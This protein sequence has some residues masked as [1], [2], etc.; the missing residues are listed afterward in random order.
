MSILAAFI[1]P[2]PPLIVPQIGKGEEETIRE[3]SESFQK[4]AEKIALLKPDTIVLA[5]PHSVM[6]SDYLHISPGSTA[7]GDFG[8]FG[9]RDVRITVAY[10]T[11][12]RRSL[13]DLINQNDIPAG[14]MGERNSTLDHGTMVP[15]Y[16]INQQYRD[17]KLIRMSIS[18]LPFLTHYNIGKCISQASEITKKKVVF[19]ASGDLSHKLKTDGPYGFAKEGPIFDKEVTEA[20]ASANFLRFMTFDESF[21]ESAAECGLRSFIIM[22]GALDGKAVKPEL[23]SYQGPFGVGYAVASFEVVGSDPDRHFD[24]AYEQLQNSKIDSI[25]KQESE[26]VRLARM[27]LEHYL[28]T[29]SYMPIPGDTSAELTNRKAGTFVSLHKDGQLRGCIGTISPNT[30]SIAEEIIHNAV[31]AG[32]GD[33]RFDPVRKDELSRIEYSVDVLSEP[34]DISSKDEL[35]HTRYG[36]I[37]ESGRRRGLLLPNLDGV[38]SVDQQLDIALQKAGISRHESFT[39]QRFEVVRYK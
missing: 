3:T 39:M 34:E 18:G 32:T 8:K 4:I 5:S 36:V 20:M 1:A 14:T 33:P 21:C 22:A 10:D 31:S 27:S 24:L 7:T 9:A 17:Y 16:F 26:P 15:L 25:R 30:N 28:K 35:D 37:V 29:G 11:E 2:H 19:V 38:N 23:L 12:F 13:I 6:Y